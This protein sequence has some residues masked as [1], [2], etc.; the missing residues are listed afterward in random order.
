MKKIKVI[1]F[2]IDGTLVDLETRVVPK[3]TLEALNKLKEKGILLFIC[4]GRN[5]GFLSHLKEE[6][7]FDFDGYIL[8]NGQY[9]IIQNECIYKLPFDET[10]K[11]AIYNKFKNNN[12]P[13]IVMEENYMFCTEKGISNFAECNLL[14]R[15]KDN[16]IY[17]I[18]P[19][20]T[21]EFDKEIE[22]EIS[23]LKSARWNPG[24]ADI[25]PK[26]GGKDKGIEVVLNKYNI[27][28]KNT[29]AFGD[30]GNDI[31]MLKKVNYG[32]AMGNANE[33]VKASAKDVTDSVLEDGI[34]NALRKYKVI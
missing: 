25:I 22:K 2:D 11:T 33:I 14:E 6:I 23:G 27:D 17:Q 21:E 32:I 16:D 30:G 10:T 29:M 9:I 19:I 1:F 28:I 20:A 3:S 31:P 18:C 13:L 12:I 26:S 7:N 24:F 15:I 8:M 4:S 5:T 34:Y